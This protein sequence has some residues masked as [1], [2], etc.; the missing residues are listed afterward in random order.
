MEELISQF[1]TDEA[2][3]GLGMSFMLI[4]IG[5]CLGRATAPGSTPNKREKVL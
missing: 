2:I 5:F 1:S 4:G 3:L